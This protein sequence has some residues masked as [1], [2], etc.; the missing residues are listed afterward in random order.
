MVE[1]Y[2]GIAALRQQNYA[3]AKEVFTQVAN[4]GDARGWYHLGTMYASGQGV[5]TNPSEAASLFRR[6]AE[7]GYTKAASSLADLYSQGNG[8]AKDTSESLKWYQLAL[9]CGDPEVAYRLG[10]MY[11]NGEGTPI[12]LVQSEKYLR[13]A[14][15][16]NH[17]KSMR[18]LGNLFKK[19][20]S[21][22]SDPE[23]Q[24]AT[25]AYWYIRSVLAGNTD[26][27]ADIWDNY[28]KL[29]A[30]ANKGV[31][32]AQFALGWVSE[33]GFGKPRDL[34]AAVRWYQSA[35]Q[36]NHLKAYLHLGDLYRQDGSMFGQSKF[37]AQDD[38]LMIQSYE[39][40]A[41][42]QDAECQHNLALCYATGMGVDKDAELA[43]AWFEKAAQQDH[44][45]SQTELA[46]QLF[47]RGHDEDN[48]QGMQW[49]LKAAE[50][51][52]CKAMKLACDIYRSGRVVPKDFTQAAR[53]LMTALYKGHTDV[54]DDY[55]ELA[56]LMTGEQLKKAD[57]LAGGDGSWS[58]ARVHQHHPA[59]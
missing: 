52:D 17:A 37:F 41:N 22:A 30:L 9:T 15:N 21:G 45:D 43:I 24:F 20:A 56:A 7:S 13:L 50:A 19:K 2:E 44:T 16:Q 36:Q 23:G 10:T 26:A 34:Q 58:S 28:E 32:G 11:C 29:H 1:L 38:K 3:K 47:E 53:W 8:V 18:S 57:A 6:S 14:A 42:L 35:A 59:N 4:D 40:G 27:I 5:E 46:L 31:P 39:R 48:R 54:L 25:A 33:H 55:H 51:G 49:L 12:D